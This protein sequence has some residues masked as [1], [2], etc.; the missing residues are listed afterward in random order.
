MLENGQIAV[1]EGK[2]R[3]FR[4][5][6]KVLSL[7]VPRMYR[8]KMRATN[9]YNSFVKNILLH[10]KEGLSKIHSVHTFVIKGFIL[11]ESTLLRM[12]MTIDTKR[13]YEIINILL[14]IIRET[15]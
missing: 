9:F 3:R 7:T 6:P 14:F 5:L 13:G 11:V 8:I 12:Q 4:I 1:F 2:C 15:K 10:M